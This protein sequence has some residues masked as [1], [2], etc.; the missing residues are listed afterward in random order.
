LLKTK[1]IAMKKPQN[2]S[3]KT[4]DHLAELEE[5]DFGK[6]TGGKLVQ[7]QATLL[8]QYDTVPQAPAPA[9]KDGN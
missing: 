3:K 9:P 5:V 2:D 4:L 1:R 8:H 6:V 7:S